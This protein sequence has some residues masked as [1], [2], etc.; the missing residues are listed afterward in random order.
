MYLIKFIIFFALSFLLLGFFWYYLTCFNAIYVNTKIY[1][2]ENTFIS[3]AFS[4]FYPFLINLIPMSLRRWAIKSEE[5]DDGLLY[6]IS[7]FIQII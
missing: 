2:I 6:Q 1:L 7:Q 4:L 3:F 5:K